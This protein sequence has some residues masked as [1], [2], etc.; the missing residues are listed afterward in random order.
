[1]H[2][3]GN[4][5]FSP[6]AMDKMGLR[7]GDRVQFLHTQLD[8]WY[9]IAHPDGAVIRNHGGQNRITCRPMVNHFRWLYG[10]DTLCFSVKTSPIAFRDTDAFSLEFEGYA[11][12]SSGS[13]SGHI[14]D[15]ARPSHS[16]SAMAPVAALN[17]H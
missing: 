2:A 17:R 10:F 9:V 14:R 1:M 3:C 4:V 7:P 5:V 16:A 11:G 8:C 13:T 15:T 6:Q 12:A